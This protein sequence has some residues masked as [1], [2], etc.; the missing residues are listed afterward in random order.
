M[1]GCR[2]FLWG[3]APFKV[4][5]LKQMVLTEIVPYG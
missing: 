4:L 1:A 3:N 2:N 5:Q